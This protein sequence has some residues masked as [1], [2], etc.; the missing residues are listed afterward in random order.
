MERGKGR[1]LLQLF[2]ESDRPD[3]YLSISEKDGPFYTLA[4]LYSI[5][6]YKY[7]ADS[8]QYCHRNQYQRA[9]KCR[10]QL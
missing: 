4:T 3:S 2:I 9:V 5:K 8:T 10:A 6:N 1:E 7:T